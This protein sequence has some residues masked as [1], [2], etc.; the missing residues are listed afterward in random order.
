MRNALIQFHKEKLS[1]HYLVRQHLNIWQRLLEA[2]P[3]LYLVLV[4][5]TMFLGM[6]P[7][8]RPALI[9][10]VWLV[11][12]AV[13]MF[14]KSRFSLMKLLM[15]KRILM[16][17]EIF[18]RENKVKRKYKD[19][20]KCL[21]RHREHEIKKFLRGSSKEK[22]L[23]AFRDL[24]D[25]NSN[26]RLFFGG[27]VGVVIYSRIEKILAKFNFFESPVDDLLVLANHP[28]K[29]ET[30]Y[31]YVL[32]SILTIEVVSAL[33]AI[34]LSAF[35]YLLIKAYIEFKSSS[36]ESLIN[37]LENIVSEKG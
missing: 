4:L 6:V 34:C 10:T 25:R 27:A 12:D 37:L 16:M 32:A 29:V 22:I 35:P 21:R 23:E 17:M 20:F 28:E 24:R 9:L 11:V 1:F 30:G 33:I 14:F 13:L 18:L 26:F 3:V 5:T 2:S 31:S 7:Q 19:F 15:E 36:L 8:L